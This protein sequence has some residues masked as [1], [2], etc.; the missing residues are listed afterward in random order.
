MTYYNALLNKFDICS[1]NWMISATKSQ[2]SMFQFSFAATANKAA[3]NAN[4][5]KLQTWLVFKFSPLIYYICILQLKS[6]IFLHLI[7]HLHS[8]IKLYVYSAKGKNIFT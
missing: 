5:L 2:S 4:G 1:G 8:K 7:I 3:R 6:T